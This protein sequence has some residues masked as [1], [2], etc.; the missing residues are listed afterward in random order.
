[1][2]PQGSNAQIIALRVITQRI[3]STPHKKLPHTVPFLASSIR[4]TG[5]LLATSE[6][7]EQTGEG[8]DPSVL[9]HKFKTQISSLL[10]EKNSEARWSAVV[11]V[12]ATVEA[13]GWTVLQGAGNWVRGLL[14]I[15]AVCDQF[16]SCSHDCSK[17]LREA[18]IGRGRTQ[19]LWQRVS[20]S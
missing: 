5:D 8:S 17:M 2:A 18:Y 3:S 10:Q 4:N 14:G 7:L 16:A 15:L 1:M 6:S 12:K 20:A 11:L 13:G 19:Y 9:V